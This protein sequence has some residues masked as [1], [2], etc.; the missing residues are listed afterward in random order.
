MKNSELRCIAA[1]TLHRSDS[2][3][4]AFLRRLK[5]RLGAPKAITATAHK[6]AT[7]IFNMLKNGVE[8]IETGQ[9]YYETQY[10]DRLVKNLNRRAKM[11]GYELV[12]AAC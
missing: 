7:I 5:A 2:A 12:E 1:S 6:L 3:L 11:L 9:D 8:Y 10:R 4:G